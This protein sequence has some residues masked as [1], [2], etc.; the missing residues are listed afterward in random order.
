EA[1]PGIRL[2]PAGRLEIER[3]VLD[4]PFDVE[5]DDEPAVVVR[6]EGLALIALR[7]EPLL[8]AHDLIP[9]PLPVQARLVVRRDD[10][11]ELRAKRKLRFLHREERSGGDHHDDGD[12]DDERKRT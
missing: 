9:R 3:G 11:T 12:E 2:E 6:E 10:R 7:D 8:E 4:A 5:I 1:L